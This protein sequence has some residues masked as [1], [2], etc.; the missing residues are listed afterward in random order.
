V[1]SFLAAKVPVRAPKASADLLSIEGVKK[2]WQ[3]SLPLR[4]SRTNYLVVPVGFDGID[5]SLDDKQ[6]IDWHG[7]KL[8]IVATPG[9]SRD[10]IAIKAQKGDSAPIIFCGDALSSPGKM[11]SPFTTDWDHWTDAGLKPS[12]ESLRKLQDLKPAKLLP[13]HGEVLDKDAVAVLDKTAKAV[14]EVGFLKSFERFSKQRLGN[15]PEYRFLAKEQAESNGS[16]PWTKVSEHLWLTGNTY[17]LTSKEDHHFLVMDPWDKRSADQIAKL[18]ADQKLGSMEVVMFSH[19]H[20]DHY[21]GI[22][23]LSEYTGKDRDTL[24]VWTLDKASTPLVDPFLLRAPFI[25]VRPIKFDR[26]YKEGETAE[27][28]EYRFRFHHLPGQ[29]EFTM[30]VECDIDGKRCLFTA[31]NW[32]HQDQ[33]SGSGGWMGLNRSSPLPYAAS[34]KKVLGIAPEWVLA[35]HGGP[36]EFNEEDF[37]RRVKWGEVGGQAADEMCVNGDHRAD[38]D[39]HRVHFEPILQKAKPGATIKGTLVVNNPLARKVKMS[40]TLEGRGLT[41]DQSW[42][43]EVPAKGSERRAVTVTVSETLATGRHIFVLATRQDGGPEGS[44]AFFAVDVEN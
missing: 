23:H 35:E 16:K 40:V 9:H 30:G 21:D 43:L 10:H 18:K 36:F 13:A 12:A 11:W 7:W 38:W 5:F 26:L 25:D 14:E 22:Y 24:K 6:E 33:F 34:A 8:H 1:G 44:D 17:V 42:E 28:R 32:F 41:T 3:D 39:P 19:A 15:A 29:T 31:D 2:Y 27:W 20:Y 4:N 37:K